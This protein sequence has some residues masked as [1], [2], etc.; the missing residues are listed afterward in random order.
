MAGKKGAKHE[1]ARINVIYLKQQ[2][3]ENIAVVDFLLPGKIIVQCDGDYW[4]NLP[5]RKVYDMKQDKKLMKKG[6]T[7]VRFTETEIKKSPENCLN[8]VL[9]V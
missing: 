8:K 4:H 7:I 5:G 2:A 9:G 3:I 6:Y 1:G